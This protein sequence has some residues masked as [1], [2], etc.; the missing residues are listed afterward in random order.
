MSD[1]GFVLFVIALCTIT[2]VLIALVGA[3]R[4]V[5]TG[6]QVSFGYEEK[7]A[8]LA[9]ER[10]KR[11]LEQSGAALSDVAFEA[12]RKGVREALPPECWMAGP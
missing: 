2:F 6:T 3:P 5:L 11:V 9:F 4:V 1:R 7:D 12:K 10:M 8:R